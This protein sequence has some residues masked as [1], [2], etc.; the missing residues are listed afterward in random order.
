MF[1][2]ESVTAEVMS[3]EHFRTDYE[4]TA[5]TSKG[6]LSSLFGSS[7]TP[8]PKNISYVRSEYLR[9]RLELNV[10]Y[11]VSRNGQRITI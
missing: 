7:R 8:A 6:W 11:R 10:L 9:N 3:K 5:P 2:F 1:P 4:T